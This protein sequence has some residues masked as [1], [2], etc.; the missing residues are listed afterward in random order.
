[1]IAELHRL[2]GTAGL[3]ADVTEDEHDTL[4]NLDPLQIELK[5]RIC[6]NWDAALQSVILVVLQERDDCIATVIR[7]GETCCYRLFLSSLFDEFSLQAVQVFREIDLF[8]W[9]E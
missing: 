3:G 5:I 8:V 6:N 7:I 9:N 4:S 2:H 1:M